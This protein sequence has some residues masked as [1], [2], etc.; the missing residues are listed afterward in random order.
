VQEE[1]FA[2]MAK[3]FNASMV[4]Y[5]VYIC[6]LSLSH[7]SRSPKVDTVGIQSHQPVANATSG[8]VSDTLLSA[9][10]FILPPDDK[11]Q[12]R[13]CEDEAM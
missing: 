11:L 1:I 8:V 12:V 13:R 7:C 2:A 9:E 10:E 6:A 3:E 5:S 4:R